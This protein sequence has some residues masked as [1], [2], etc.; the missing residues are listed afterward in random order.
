MNIPTRLALT[1]SSLAL[2]AGSVFAV[3]AATQ[4]S[5][6][7]TTAVPQSVAINAPLIPDPHSRD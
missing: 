6:A 4:A 5:T 7:A 2:A 1:V 3:G